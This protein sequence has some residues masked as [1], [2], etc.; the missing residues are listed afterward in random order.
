[1]AGSTAFIRLSA[2]LDIAKAHFQNDSHLSRGESLEE[3]WLREYGEDRRM[4]QHLVLEAKSPQ[5][6]EINTRT[7]SQTEAP[8]TLRGLLAQRRRWLLGVLCTDAAALCN[9]DLCARQPAVSLYRLVIP[10]IHVADPQAFLLIVL[11]LSLESP[12]LQPFAVIMGAIFAIHW[13]AIICYGLSRARCS[14]LLY[15]LWL[16]LMPFFNV[17]L[18]V[19]TLFTVRHRAWGGPRVQ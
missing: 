15:P 7:L 14:V 8:S 16:L 3:Y 12:I 18:R 9:P 1:M 11:I 17:S 5:P 19:Y 10:T 4:T 2:L 13:L 6:L